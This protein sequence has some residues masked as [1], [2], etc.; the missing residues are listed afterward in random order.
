M[1]VVIVVVV[2]EL[3]CSLLLF[4]R[5]LVDFVVVFKFSHSFCFDCCW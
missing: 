5:L 4:F 1:D 2:V 3:F